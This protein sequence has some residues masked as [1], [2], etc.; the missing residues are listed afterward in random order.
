MEKDGILV[1]IDLLNASTE[2]YGKEKN[3]L[4]DYIEYIVTQNDTIGTI[5]LCNEES[6]NNSSICMS[7]SEAT[8]LSANGCHVF[9]SGE[10]MW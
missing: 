7:L 2:I 1:L 9:K 3:I 5:A 4:E 6:D 10:I 8:R